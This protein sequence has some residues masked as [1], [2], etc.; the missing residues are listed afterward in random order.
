LA[1]GRPRKT[2]A[3]LPLDGALLRALYA[4]VALAMKGISML[5]G[6]RLVEFAVWGRV[7]WGGRREGDAGR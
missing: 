3:P 2:Y 6:R 1:P 4:D 7:G 5:S